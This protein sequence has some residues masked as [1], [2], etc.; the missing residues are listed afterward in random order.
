MTFLTPIPMLIAAGLAT[1]VLLAYYFLKLRRRPVRVSSVQFWESS[2]RDLQVNVPLRMLRPTWLLLLHLLILALFLMALGRPAINTSGAPADRVVILIDTS[3]SMSGADVEPTRLEAAK[4]Q[5]K[6]LVDDLARSDAEVMVI[7]FGATPTPMTSFTRN[8]RELRRA[9][10]AVTP[11]DQPG[12]LSRALALVDAFAQGDTDEDEAAPA[13]EAVLFSDG[14]FADD[15][16]RTL[17]RATFSFEHTG[18]ATDRPANNLAVVGLSGARDPDQPEL[19]RVFA[20]VQSNRAEPAPISLRLFADGEEHTARAVTVPP[21]TPTALGEAVQT[22]QLRRLG[23]TL[24]AVSIDA[25]DDLVSDNA[26]ALVVSGAPPT[27]DPVCLARG[28]ARRLGG[29]TGHQRGARGASA[30]PARSARSEWVPRA[31]CRVRRVRPRCA[32]PCPSDGLATHPDARVRARLRAGGRCVRRR[33]RASR[34]HRLVGSRRPRAHRRHARRGRG[35]AGPA[36]DSF[37]GRGHARR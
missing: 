29:R 26:A 25:T 31:G 24:L 22:F 5:A 28:R 20:R 34:R 23:P 10:D 36:G 7:A 17:R 21:G 15:G 37:A 14:A 30:E 4:A 12:D 2:T 3:A 13:T 35:R 19:I 33:P 27:A 8:P 11:T 16:A 6:A 1:P 18:P 32:R 9:I